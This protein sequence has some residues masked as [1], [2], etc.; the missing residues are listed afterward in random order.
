MSLMADSKIRSGPRFK[1]KNQIL[2]ELAFNAEPYYQ[3][4]MELNN[5][6]DH[7]KFDTVHEIIFILCELF[8]TLKT[9]P[10]PFAHSWKDT[11]QESL[12]LESTFTLESL[13]E[14]E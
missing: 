10:F 3:R 14:H 13:M 7:R 1:C 6:L 12:Y 9:K 4:T 2:P 5:N 8:L 11:R